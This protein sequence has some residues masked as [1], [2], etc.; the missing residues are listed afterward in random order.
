M[1]L[2]L[3][4]AMAMLVTPATAYDTKYNAGASAHAIAVDQMVKHEIAG[5]RGIE[6]C[7]FIDTATGH[8]RAL[9]SRYANGG[10]ANASASA[11]ASAGSMGSGTG[12]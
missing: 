10:G 9:V 6:F 1:R 12:K 2:I 7:E 11:S 5:K 8:C 3:A 4:L